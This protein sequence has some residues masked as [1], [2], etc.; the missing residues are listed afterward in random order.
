MK[1]ILKRELN[2][3]YLILSS[4]ETGYEESYELQM[5]ERNAPE[6][7]L[8]LNVR[9]VDEELQ[10]FYDV[11][12]KQTLAICAE[13]EKLTAH[14]IRKLFESIDRMLQEVR[15]YLLDTESVVLDLE[16][17]YTKESTF[18]FCYCPWEKQDLLTALRNMLEEILGKIDY[19]DTEGVELTYHLYQ[20][21]CRGSISIKEILEEHCKEEKKQEEDSFLWKE[22]NEDLE[23]EKYSAFA[24]EEKKQNDQGTKKGFFGRMMQLFL[25]KEVKDYSWEDSKNSLDVVREERNYKPMLKEA[26]ITSDANTVLMESMPTGNWKL[27]PIVQGHDIFE[28]KGDNFV[29][30]KKREAVDGYIERDTISRIHSRLWVKNGRLYISDANSTNGTYVNGATIEP[31]QEVEIFP[32]DRILFAD[33]GYECYNS[34]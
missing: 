21:A 31:G 4:E 18:F 17:I 24:K 30:G 5:I 11:S 19:H 16:H 8:A 6:T 32:G 1:E 23:E 20:S 28:I 7:I 14:T 26:Q 34:L 9:R 22:P 29:I 3:T 27:C 13:R 10:L 12:S 15:D 33:V 25:K 2:K